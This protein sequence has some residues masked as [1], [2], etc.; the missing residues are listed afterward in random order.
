MMILLQISSQSSADHGAVLLAPFIV[1]LA[2]KLV[3][4]L[5]DRIRQ[6]AVV[7]E[8]LAGILIGLSVLKLLQSNGILEALSQ[9]G[10]ILLLLSVGLETRPKLAGC[11]LAAARMGRQKAIQVGVGMIPPGEVG[12]VVAQLGV[13]MAA[14][15]GAVYGMVLA[16]AVVKTLIAPP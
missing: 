16:M 2:A 11:G 10:V 6:P 7:G 1:L 13:A 14:V 9:I 3:A 4:E 8:I 5:C 12:I 15:S